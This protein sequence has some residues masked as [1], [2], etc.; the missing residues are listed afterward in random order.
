M[1]EYWLID[2]QRRQVEFYSLGQNRTHHLILPEN[3]VFRSGV[4]VGFWL[5]VDWLWQKPL[6]KVLDVLREWHIG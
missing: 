1:K 2:P 5:R 6:P 4:L 3:G